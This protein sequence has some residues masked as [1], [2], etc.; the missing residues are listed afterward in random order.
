MPIFRPTPKIF[1]RLEF[2]PGFGPSL[3]GFFQ[4]LGVSE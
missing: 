4:N 2:F 3:P 1:Y